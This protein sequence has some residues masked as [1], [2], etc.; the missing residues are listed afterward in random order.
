LVMGLGQGRSFSTSWGAMAEC[1]GYLAQLFDFLDH[2]V[3]PSEA[4]PGPAS[5][6]APAPTVA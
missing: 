5:R 6:G 4:A 2:P 3:D 1:L